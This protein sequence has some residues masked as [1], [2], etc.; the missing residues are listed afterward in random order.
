MSDRPTDFSELPSYKA[1]RRSLFSAR[2]FALMAS[3]V[4]G[5][6]FYIRDGEH[7]FGHAPLVDLR[8]RGDDA[9][10]VEAHAHVA[11]RGDDV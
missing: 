2:K 11:V 1:P 5:L 7:L 9:P 6:A 8:G 3:V 4:E 10:V